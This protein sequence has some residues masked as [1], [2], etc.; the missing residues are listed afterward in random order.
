MALDT[1]FARRIIGLLGYIINLTTYINMDKETK[2][3]I[4]EL[5][6]KIDLVVA[7]ILKLLPKK[8]E[9]QFK[10]QVRLLNDL[11]VRP[12]DMSKLTGRTQGHVGKELV[13]IRK[14]K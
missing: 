3:L 14:E 1:S 7:L 9:L 5:G 10:D 11:K 6:Q 4:L 2:E 13:A 8:E 12:M